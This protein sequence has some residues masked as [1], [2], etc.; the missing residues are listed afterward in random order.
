LDRYF[1]FLYP[2]ADVLA[3]AEG[4]DVGA[5]ETRSGLQLQIPRITTYTIRGKVIGDLPGDLAKTSVMFR[6][7]FGTIVDEVGGGSGVPVQPDGS[8]EDKKHPGIYNAE[9]MEFSAPN[10]V[11]R[12]H[13]VRQLGKVKLDLT[14]GDLDDVEIYVSADGEK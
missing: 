13:L 7:D 5:G 8:F 14:R 4:F 2:N 6:R 3:G 12:V 11:G 1:D 9:I 10:Q